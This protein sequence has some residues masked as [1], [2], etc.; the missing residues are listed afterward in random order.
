MRW[1][2]IILALLSGLYN[3]YLRANKNYI[4]CSWVWIGISAILF[5]DFAFGK[6][7]DNSI[8]TL[9]YKGNLFLAIL[10][11]LSFG[12]IWASGKNTYDGSE[13]KIMILAGGFQ[14]NGQL[15]TDTMA[16]LQLGLYLGGED[17]EYIITGGLLLNGKREAELMKQIIIDSGVDEKRIII[18]VNA[19]DTHQ[20][21]VNCNSYL[22]DGEDVVV[23]SSRYHLLRVKMLLAKYDI[24]GIHVA[25]AST[26]MTLIPHNYVREVCSII[27][28]T[29][30]GWIDWSVLWR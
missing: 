6:I 26:N 29:F 13:K 15:S 27:R 14:R 4:D 18:D 1:G 25:G 5:V 24:R 11:L 10:L 30:F 9:W 16:R 20:N 28:D 3:L 22:A 19:N 23:V 7:F 8:G 21:I 17:S 2:L 12:V